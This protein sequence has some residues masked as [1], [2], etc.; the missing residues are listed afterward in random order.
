[1]SDH[2]EL[3]RVE[4]TGDSDGF[5]SRQCPTCGR[6]FKLL[7]FR[8]QN[9][10]APEAAYC[11]YCGTTP[12]S[13]WDTGDQAAYLRA[14][15][16]RLGAQYVAR[17]FREMLDGLDSSIFKVS[18][19]ESSLPPDPGTPPLEQTAGFSLV[20]VPCHPDDPLKIEESWSGEVGCPICGITYPVSDVAELGPS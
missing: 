14:H 6:V 20:R 11:P 12:A 10:T 17:R 19:G 7:V 16:E 1:L 8:M 2:I 13:R 5:L 15:V 4:L 9:E 3:G 18:H